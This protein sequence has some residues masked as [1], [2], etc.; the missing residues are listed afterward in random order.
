MTCMS[1]HIKWSDEDYDAME[2]ELLSILGKKLDLEL[3]PGHYNATIQEILTSS[4]RE[5]SHTACRRTL[6]EKSFDG[7]EVLDLPYEDL[8]TYVNE[9]RLVASAVVRWRLREG[10]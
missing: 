8:L 5:M 9:K 4:Y 1:S 2:M 10:R 6:R 3:L 7:H